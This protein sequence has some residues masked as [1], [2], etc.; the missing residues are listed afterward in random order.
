MN[1]LTK[2]IPALR[3]PIA[4][5]LAWGI[6]AVVAGLAVAPLDPSLLEEGI[7]VHT[8]QRML[9]GEQLYRDVVSHTG[10]LP[11][12]LLAALL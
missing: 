4:A 11:Y 8:A 2:K 10:P 6:A 1:G 12:E 9:G 3:E 5:P 7:V